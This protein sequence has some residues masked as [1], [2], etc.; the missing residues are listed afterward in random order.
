[1]EYHA[2]EYQ[3]YDEG[4]KRDGYYA[5]L[6]PGFYAIVYNTRQIPEGTLKSIKDLY[7]PKYKGRIA[8]C[9]PRA[10][11]SGY[12]AFFTLLNDP[13]YGEEFW[14]K[15]GEQKI[16]V[17]PG[18]GNLYQSVSSGQYAIGVMLTMYRWYIGEQKGDPV[19]AFFPPEGTMV[20]NS[21]GGILKNAAHPN[22]AKV[23]FSFLASKEGQDISKKLFVF[24]G[25][26]EVEPVAGVPARFKRVIT[27]DDKKLQAQ[28]RTAL[29]EK[30]DRLVKK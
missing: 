8:M 30:F 24:S 15:M 1:M 29:L 7:D 9:D 27:T 11:S 10:S 3:Y 28:D 21:Y 18:H 4:D 12:E 20:R 26:R 25:H 2:P 16:A 13:Q 23:L 19:K 5:A 6:R 17:Q 22:A 14:K